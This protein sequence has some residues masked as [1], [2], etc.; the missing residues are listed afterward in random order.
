LA[1][2]AKTVTE[3]KINPYKRRNESSIPAPLQDS[4]DGEFAAGPIAVEEATKKSKEKRKGKDKLNAN[5]TR[6]TD[7][8]RP[9][10]KRRVES[11]EEYFSDFVNDSVDIVRSRSVSRT[12]PDRNKKS[13]NPL[14]HYF[15]ELDWLE[16]SD[17]DDEKQDHDEEDESSDHEHD[18]KIPKT[19][20][21]LIAAKGVSTETA[22]PKIERGFVIFFSV[23]LMPTWSFRCRILSYRGRILSHRGRI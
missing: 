22:A 21:V 10:K 12:P 20:A 17:A 14:G 1:I 15:A 13:A 16:E 4:S 3:T 11:D 2:R 9:R 7:S 8:G 5:K 19:M 6:S 23:C 18:L